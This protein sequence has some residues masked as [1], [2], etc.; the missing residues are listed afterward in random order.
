MDMRGLSTFIS[1]VR[2]A[3][4]KEEED[5]RINA[6]LAKI[7]TKFKTNQKMKGYDRKKYICKILYIYM[8]GYDIDFGHMEAI[9]LVTSSKYSE[10]ATGYLAVSLLL[11]ETNE[12]LTLVIQSI[13]KDLFAHDENIVCLA[14]TT[15]ANV[16]GREFAEVLSTDVLKILTSGETKSLVRDSSTRYLLHQDYFTSFFKRHGCDYIH[17]FSTFGIGYSQS[18]SV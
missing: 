15:I 6:E 7:R 1:D 12:I 5:E 9:E 16:G 13:K 18:T 17:T 8:L 3:Q 4:T 14:L 11:D 2:K 10:K